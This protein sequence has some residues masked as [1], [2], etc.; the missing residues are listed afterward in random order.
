MRWVIERVK[1]FSLSGDTGNNEVGA[2]AVFVAVTIIM[3]FGFVAMS[4][5]FGRIY[6]ERRQ[7]QNGADAAA[8]AVAQDCAFGDC[9]SSLEQ[10]AT[11]EVYADANARDGLAWV[12]DIDLDLGNQQVTVFN[13]TEDPGG[14]HFFDTTF[15]KVI[16]Y[17]GLTVHA[18][19]T[20]AWGPP[21]GL[22]TLPIAF[23]ICEWEKYETSL[24]PSSA[25]IDNVLPPTPG[26]P[27]APQ[28]VFFHGSEESCHASPSGQDLPGGFGWLE[29]PSVCEANIDAGGWVGIDPGASPS[30]GCDP[31]DLENIVGTVQLIPYFDDIVGVGSGAQYHVAGF[32]ALYVTG[33]NFAGRF[34][35]R[36]TWDGAQ[37]CTGEDR[38][39]E[40][41]FIDDWV[42]EGGTPGGGTDFGVVVIGF[43]G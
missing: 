43:V 23:S 30:R 7:L 27:T 18:D 40:G 21:S 13:V 11:A 6:S 22:A 41:Y 4:V 1:N 37:V 9:G 34:K 15:A 26:Y 36:S 20:V 29:A 14:D 39:L 24:T 28:T 5:D 42:V 31:V 16:G 12:E 10:H 8:L 38:C 33:Y 32:G 2:V 19:A 25:V 35:E 3:L 17:D